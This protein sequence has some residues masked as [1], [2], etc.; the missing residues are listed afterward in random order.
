MRL[1]VSMQRRKSKKDVP[2]LQEVFILV[3]ET[4]TRTI[5]K[6]SVLVFTSFNSQK[7]LMGILPPYS[8]TMQYIEFVHWM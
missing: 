7:W 8:F 4:H 5:M 1:Y 3:E 6:D 2:Y